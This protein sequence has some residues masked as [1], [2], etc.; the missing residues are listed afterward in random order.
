MVP[1]TPSSCCKDFIQS[2]DHMV[3]NRLMTLCR[4]LCPS[5]YLENKPIKQ[6]YWLAAKSLAPV[7]ETW[8]LL[9]WNGLVL[10]KKLSS[11]KQKSLLLRINNQG[12]PSKL[13][14]K[15][16]WCQA[17]GCE[18]TVH[19]LSLVP[20]TGMLQESPSRS[21]WISTLPR[22]NMEAIIL[23]MLIWW[24][25]RTP[26]EEKDAWM[27]SNLCPKIEKTFYP[28]KD[29]K[30]CLIFLPGLMVPKTSQAK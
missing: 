23:K 13:R 4:I 24:D 8:W 7:I 3:L 15:W 22:C 26:E 21:D 18:L 11:R 20:L 28:F 9:I 10:L 30:N 12:V 16:P 19:I 27:A 5:E 17:R 25:S 2:E 29:F 1:N 6:I 14:G